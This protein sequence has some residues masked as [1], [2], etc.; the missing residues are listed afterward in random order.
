MIPQVDPCKGLGLPPGLRYD[1]C[2]YLRPDTAYFL[3]E[4]QQLPL[5]VFLRFGRDFKDHQLCLG[6]FVQRQ[7][8]GCEETVKKISLN[9]FTGN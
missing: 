5:K 6:Q 3:D 8:S 4:S 1:Q 9:D 2:R 7:P